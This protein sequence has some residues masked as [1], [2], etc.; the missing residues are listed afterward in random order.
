MG[1]Y[2]VQDKN[3]FLNQSVKMNVQKIFILRTKRFQ[4]VKDVMKLV[5]NV[6]AQKNII[7]KNVPKIKFSSKVSA[8][9]NVL[10]IL[11]FSRMIPIKNL[12]KNV[13]KF[14][15]PVLVLKKM[16]VHPVTLTLRKDFSILTL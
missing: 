10:E 9:L 4:N 8:Y 14:V 11:T 3:F 2:L 13:T 6:T 5:F 16:T 7:A 12:A 15:K 1:V